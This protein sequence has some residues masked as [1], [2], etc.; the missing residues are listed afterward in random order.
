MGS[1]VII[2]AISALIGALVGFI[3]HRGVTSQE[4]ARKQQYFS[5][6]RQWADE[7]VN[8]LSEAVHI[9]EIDPSLC[10]APSFF[11]RRHKLKVNISSL[12]DRGRWFF[13]N[14]K[15]TEYGEWKPEAYKGF[16]HPAL[17]SLIYTY[18]A[19]H[20]M[21]YSNGEKNKQFREPLVAVKKEFVS[22]IQRRLDPRKAQEEYGRA[23]RQE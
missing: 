20:N 19:I 21:D 18:K 11:N 9:C 2:A 1:E 14:L 8:I 4:R 15:H 17:D 5:D 13:P 22:E 16:R 10:E 7:A 23:M 12:I 6:L 3:T